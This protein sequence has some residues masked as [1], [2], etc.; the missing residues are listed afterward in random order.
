MQDGFIKVASITPRVRVADV[1]FNVESCLAAIEEAAGNRGA[2]VVVLPELC[3]TGYT[4]EDLFWQDALLD[5]AERGLVSIAARTA[6][7][8]AL[9]LLGLPVRVAGSS[10]ASTSAVRAAM[11]TNPRSAASRRASCQNRSSQV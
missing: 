8:D 1:A 3:I 2:K 9:L 7:V 4:C 11:E 5:A 10:N 6:D